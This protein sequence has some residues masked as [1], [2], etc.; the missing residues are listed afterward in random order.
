MLAALFLDER[1]NGWQL[2]GSAMIIGSVLVLELAEARGRRRTP[3]E[4][5][6]EEL[7]S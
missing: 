4:H 7:A 6:N 1:L 2:L 5:L 3:A